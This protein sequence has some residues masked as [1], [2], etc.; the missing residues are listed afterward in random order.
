[1]KFVNEHAMFT[2]H[3]LRSMVKYDLGYTIDR[4]MTIEVIPHGE[5]MYLAA[6][7]LIQI[8]VMQLDTIENLILEVKHYDDIEHL[9]FDILKFAI[10]HE[11]IH[12]WQYH[13]DREMSEK[14]ANRRAISCLCRNGFIED[15]T[16]QILENLF[17]GV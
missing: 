11:L 9:R 7:N 15:D 12:V 4:N 5:T 3:S 1:M 10:L 13:T 2:F 8:S 6:S 14:D 17:I 16:A